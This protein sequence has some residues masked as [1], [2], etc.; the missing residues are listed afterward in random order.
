MGDPSRV[1]RYCT[2]AGSRKDV[3]EIIKQLEKAGSKN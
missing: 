2:E 1:S 3:Q